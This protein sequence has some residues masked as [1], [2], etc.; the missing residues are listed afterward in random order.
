MAAKKNQGKLPAKAPRGRAG[1]A[2]NLSAIHG[3]RVT[4]QAKDV[5]HV[6][7]VG[8]ILALYSKILQDLPA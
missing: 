2:T 8:K 7:Y 5:K 3:K 6:I 1:K 4:I